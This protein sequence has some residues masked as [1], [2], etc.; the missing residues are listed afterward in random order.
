M[1]DRVVMATLTEGG[2]GKLIRLIEIV[3]SERF[4]LTAVWIVDQPGL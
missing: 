1:S 3:Q 4:V 2:T